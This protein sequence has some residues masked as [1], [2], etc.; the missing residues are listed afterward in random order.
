MCFPKKKQLMRT[1]VYS[2]VNSAEAIAV[3][4]G[5]HRPLIVAVKTILTMQQVVRCNGRC[6]FAWSHVRR[7]P[8][9]WQDAN[10]TSDAARI[11]WC[12]AGQLIASHPISDVCRP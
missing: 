8:A 10:G 6:A 4:P 9:V 12:P 11:E 2:Y 5:T 7:A 3:L 1:Q